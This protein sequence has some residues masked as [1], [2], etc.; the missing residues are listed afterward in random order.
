MESKIIIFSNKYINM[1]SSIGYQLGKNRRITGF[2][3]RH[4]HITHHTEVIA[5]K[6]ARKIVNEIKK[7]ID[8]GSYRITG[9][10]R[11]PRQPRKT[12]AKPRKPTNKAGRPR[13]PKT[14]VA[15]KPR[16]PKRTLLKRRR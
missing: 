10:G 1:P 2:G 4:L 12:L 13:K 9:T 16:A 3:E 7:V 14:H 6:A 5:Q 15:K 11:K 8:G